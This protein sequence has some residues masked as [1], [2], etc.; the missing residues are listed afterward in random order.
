MDEQRERIREDLRGL[1]EGDLLLGTVDRL[2]YA[3]DGS[4]YEIDPLGVVVPRTRRDVASLV[5]YAA[6]RGIPIHARGAGSGLAGESLGPGLV[7]DFSRYLRRIIQ[8]SEDTVVVEPGAVLDEVN[9]LL[10]PGGRRLGPDPSGSAVCTIGGMIA[11]DA[12]GARSIRYGTALDSVESLEVVFANG[13]WGR[14]GL[15]PWPDS[16]QDASGFQES[17]SRR[18]ALHL[19]WH[20]EL[21]ARSMPRSPRNRAGYALHRIASEEGIHLGQL[22]AGSE[23]TLALITEATLKTVPLPPAQ[24]VV[25]LSF[26]RLSDA[27]EAVLACLEAVPSACDL[28]DWR[29]LIVARDAAPEL[30]PWITEAAEAALVVE[31]EGYD[32]ADVSDQANSL[33]TLLKRRGTLAAEPMISTRRADCERWINLRRYVIPQQLRSRSRTRP[34]PVVEDVAVSPES[35]P[36]FLSELQHIFKKRGVSWTFHAHAGAGQVHA[37]PF[38]DLGDPAQLAM[39]EPLATEVYEAAWAVGGTISG[40]HGCGL[41]RSQ[42]IKRQYGELAHVFR[43]IKYA[44]DP[45]N[46]LNP[47]KIVADDSHLM[48]RDL[49]GRFPVDESG[50]LTEGALPVLNAPLRWLDRS[51]AEQA[52]ACNGCGECRTREPSLRMCPTFRATRSEAATPR[53]HVNL[54]R[55][56]AA[57]VLDPRLW[58]G[59]QMRENAGL[60]VHCNLCREEC[61]AGIDVSSMMLEAKAAYVEHHGLS[62]SDWTFSRVDFWSRM[63]SYLP[64]LSNSLM[65]NRRVRWLLERTVGLSRRRVLPR[66]HRWPFL[67][68]ADRRGLTRPRPHLSG[69]RV[70]YFLDIFPNYFDQETAD[71]VVAV[72]EHAGVNVFVPRGQRGCGLPA[73]FAGDFDRA[74]ELMSKNLRILSEAVRDGY[75]VVCSE[76]SATLMLTQEALKLT[77]DLDAELV[78]RNTM[79]VGQYLAGLKARGELP[80]PTVPLP[81]HVGY[82]QPCHLRA[83]NVGTPGLDLLR[84]VPRLETEFIDRGCSGMAGTFGMTRKNF[85]LSLRAG[86]GLRERLKSPDIEFGATECGACRIQ[87]EQGI[88]KQTHHPIKLLSLAYGLNPGLRR[89]YKD[90]R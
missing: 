89:T 66:A 77:D 21:I 12:A 22:L 79:D 45:Q 42:F 31:F 83:L 64:I 9:A 71:A 62:S 88:A 15:E 69:P 7:V 50:E 46:I 90:P 34:L 35:L 56:V 49:R 75:T 80:E 57:G 76:P 67:V 39:L 41:V 28:V 33:A 87:M 40:E 68:R 48:L 44:F 24:G 29:R 53:A 74:R 5:R 86:R 37:R 11:G 73:Y 61:P 8:I 72:L 20:R 16:E 23:G 38:L 58:S 2:P 54:L 14:L 84:G 17:L 43:E 30:R 63:A 78:A 47:G 55:Q 6:E 3:H 26:T 81:G 59:E 36:V 70:A 82:H 60:C 19:N 10:L 25:L 52:S 85:L 18:V 4:L 27:T 13:E 51:R 65:G 1:I 32:A